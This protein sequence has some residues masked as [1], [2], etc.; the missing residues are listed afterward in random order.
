MVE[1]AGHFV[2]LQASKKGPQTGTK[3]THRH[4]DNSIPMVVT[5]NLCAEMCDAKYIPANLIRW[6]LQDRIYLVGS[7][8]VENVKILSSR[9]ES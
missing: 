8:E 4:S 1:C 7:R 2:G 9:P 3:E 6:R 5:L